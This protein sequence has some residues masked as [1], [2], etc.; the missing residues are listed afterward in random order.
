MKSNFVIKWASVVIGLLVMVSC[1]DKT[2]QVGIQWTGDSKITVVQ[3]VD[4]PYRMGDVS[5][6]FLPLTSEKVSTE[7]DEPWLIPE[8]QS[9]GKTSILVILATDNPSSSPR[10]GGVKLIAGRDI[11]KITVRQAGFPSAVTEKNVCYIASDGGEV[12]IKV[13]TTGKM[14]PSL[15][16]KDCGWAKI[17]RV[18]S[19]EKNGEYL[20][21][22]SIGKNS[23]FGRLVGLELF[24]DGVVPIQGLG[25]SIIQEPAPFD[26]EVALKSE[27]PG[28]LPVLLG[29]NISNLSRIR[30]LSIAGAINGLD[31]E[32]FKK[33]LSIK[34]ESGHLQPVSFDL[35]KCEI[36]AGNNSPYQLLGYRTEFV[37]FP[38]VFLDGEIPMGVFTGA[39]N[40]QSI[41]LPTHLK[42]IG[43]K[44]FMGCT[45]LQTIVIPDFVEEINSKAFFN[46]SS[47]KDI[48]LSSKSNLLA[49][50]NQVFTT[51]SILNDL[52]LPNTLT[53]LSIETF[54]GCS[55]T[56]LHLRW[57][58][59][60]E[61]KVVPNTD[62]CTL[63]VPKNTK[64]LYRQSPSWGKFKNIVE[65]ETFIE[66]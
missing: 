30:K 45:S 57:L 11:T 8:I 12:T 55:T 32:V 65:E 35:S 27:K 63:Y 14:Q 46:C 64:E 38:D 66:D 10:E 24:V 47:L 2:D 41:I 23:G 31:F 62:G 7:S 6:E 3:G 21:S 25:P 61:V 29:N 53:N 50:G 36:G 20:I 60:F 22:V 39:T 49:L 42:Y 48:K 15:F 18:T 1:V 13:A 40:L 54:L 56:G 34:D 26:A 19:G 51:G 52:Y 33:I 4:M 28:S 9:T 58:E 16:P 43:R 59:P 44:A 5:L 37:E 17:T